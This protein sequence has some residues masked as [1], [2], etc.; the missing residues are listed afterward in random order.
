[1]SAARLP[2]SPPGS[3]PLERVHAKLALVVQTVCGILLL[4]MVLFT[5]YTVV[6]RYVF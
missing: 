5:V 1:V 4:L 3:S 2:Q 6:M